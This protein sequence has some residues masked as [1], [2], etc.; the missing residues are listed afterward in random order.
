[1]NENIQGEAFS[2]RRASYPDS[3]SECSTVQEGTENEISTKLG[4]FVLSQHLTHTSLAKHTVHVLNDRSFLISRNEI[5][6]HNKLLGQGQ[7]GIVYEGAC[8][9]QPCAVKMLKCGVH[10]QDEAR[11]RLLLELNVLAAVGH[12]PN[13]VGFI[14][15]CLEDL[16][17][18]LLVEELIAGPSLEEHLATMSPG[19]D[20]GLP[21]VRPPAR[22][23]LAAAV[24]SARAARKHCRR[25]PDA[26]PC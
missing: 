1:M 5:Y 17:T 26:R 19:F 6:L 13:L 8:R 9:G 23:S 4:N 16:S 24:A 12:H 20:L 3:A 10:G 21:L 25:S 22:R 15:A 11:D 14:G 18:P 2:T 7:F